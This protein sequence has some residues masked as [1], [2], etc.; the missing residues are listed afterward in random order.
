MPKTDLYFRKP[1]VKMHP[2]KVTIFRFPTVFYLE[3]VDVYWA[4]KHPED[5]VA[6]QSLE[7]KDGG[8]LVANVETKPHPEIDYSLAGGSKFFILIPNPWGNENNDS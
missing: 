2:E 5:F 7:V 6:Y 1:R 8:L 4:Q 3:Y